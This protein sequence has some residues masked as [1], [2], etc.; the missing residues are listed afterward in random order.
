MNPSKVDRNRLVWLTDLP[1]I[2]KAGAEDLHLLGISKPSQLIGKCPFEM[3]AMLCEKT[4][5]RH[6]PCV[7][8]VFMSITRFMNGDEPQPWWKY[9]EERKQAVIPRVGKVSRLGK[10]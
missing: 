8:D 3:Y 6:D 7:I 1:N 9:T 4:A 10:A 2:G 5:T